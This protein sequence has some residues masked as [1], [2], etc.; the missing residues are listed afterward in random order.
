MY[1][2]CFSRSFVL[3]ILPCVHL[4]KNSVSRYD[5]L[6]FLFSS[7]FEIVILVIQFLNHYWGE[8]MMATRTKMIF[9][10]SDE[11]LVGQISSKHSANT[12]IIDLDEYVTVHQSSQ[13]VCIS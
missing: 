6:H 2:Y 4:N 7:R 5:H 12:L 8:I 10:T 13:V 9:L 1:E 3:S 11:D